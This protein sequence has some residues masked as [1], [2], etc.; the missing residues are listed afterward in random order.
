MS[1]RDLL[2]AWDPGR[3]RH[4]A[5]A[6]LFLAAAV[7]LF[8]GAAGRELYGIYVFYASIAAHISTSGDW[9]NLQANGQPYHHKPPLLFW[10]AAAAM[11]LLGQGGLAA[12]L[13]PRLIGLATVV[14]TV[15]VGA[16]LV[17]R[18]AAWC[19]GLVLLTSGIF[20]QSATNFRMEQGLAC[21]VLLA[22]TGIL[23]PRS[24]W[25][26]AALV[27][28]GTVF[29][30][31]TKGPV[32]LLPL[33]V[34]VAHALAAR[35][36]PWRTSPLAW[37][38]LAPLLALPLGW[39]ALQGWQ[40]GDQFTVGAD[41]EAG[42]RAAGRTLLAE[43][44]NAYGRKLLTTWGH[45]LPFFAL[46]LA[47]A[48]KRWHHP[49]A[50]PV[51]RAHLVALMVWAGVVIAG[52]MLKTGMATR[53]LVP[54]FPALA[55]IA[56]VGLVTVLRARP[57]SGV[58]AGLAQRSAA[59]RVAV[60]RGVA[61]AV[62][63]LA[64]LALPVL[65]LLPA[66]TLGDTRPQLALMRAAADARLAPDAPLAVLRLGDDT[67]WWDE[68]WCG[69]YLGRPGAALALPAAARSLTDPVPVAAPRWADCVRDRRHTGLAS[70]GPVLVPRAAWASIAAARGLREV[71][72]TRTFV[73]AE[74]LP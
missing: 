31:M 51:R 62:A 60:L 17:G 71:A 25:W 5:H 43:A 40:L 55:L 32:G 48:W 69:F 29:A 52:A 41:P 24:D 30:V 26:R 46:G 42:G 66:R 33:P 74:P 53:Y 21:G 47:V 63:L 67:K 4:R 35:R 61:I 54:A 64:A 68:T 14:L 9:L 12:T 19:A 1:V 6:A 11:N 23:S 72:R 58:L 13:F 7:A 73:L 28:L 27:Y 44:W 50:A 20:I 38:A 2:A 36:L 34:V 65:A 37:I 56:G 45:W 8:A 22:L 3:A 57:R 39:Y 18:G 16:R 70:D 49:T 10:L 59:A 15:H